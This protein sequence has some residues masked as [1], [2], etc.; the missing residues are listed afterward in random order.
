MQAAFFGPTKYA[1]LPQLVE[2]KELLLGNGLVE[3]ATFL[4]I[5]LGTLIGGVLILHPIGVEIVAATMVLV[6][7]VGVYAAWQVPVTA[8]ANPGMKVSYN[9]FKSTWKMVHHAFGNPHLIIPILGISWFWA[10]GATY[11]TQLPIFTKEILNGNEMVVTL[12][13]GVF[14]V[15]VALGSF[16]CPYIINRLHARDL[17]PLALAG[18]FLF[19]LDLCWVG[20]HAH[21]LK[22]DAL[23]GMWAFIS[24]SADHVR[25]TIDLFLVALFG[26]IF[27]VPLYTQLQTQSDETERARTIAS[28]NVVNAMFIASASVIASMMFTQGLTVLHVLLVF[29]LINIPIIA[30]V[31]RMVHHSK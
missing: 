30:V 28:N 26:G 23:M 12:F 17:S 27:I 1:I 18:V 3:G 15:G 14:T 5:L 25:I 8:I 7:L 31:R 24:A 29:S 20:Y 21:Q 11:L 19:S 16:L 6:G 9:I 4:S 10:I 13:N 22:P 2:P